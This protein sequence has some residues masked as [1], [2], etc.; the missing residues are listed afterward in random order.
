MFVGDLGLLPENQDPIHV[1]AY[2]ITHTNRAQQ[3][4][5]DD[6][7]KGGFAGHM[8]EVI[9]RMTIP[10]EAS[11]MAAR[12]RYHFTMRA[13]YLKAREILKLIRVEDWS[14]EAV[15]AKK[16]EI[17]W[18]E[19]EKLQLDFQLREAEDRDREIVNT[20]QEGKIS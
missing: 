4:E 20:Q 17:G 16:E 7:I 13:T 11:L 1:F 14:E 12:N 2:I 6:A 9:D 8:L 3:I 19:F 18:G 15:Q 10:E 5:T